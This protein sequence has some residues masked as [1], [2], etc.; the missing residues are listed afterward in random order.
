MGQGT[1]S[2]IP[3]AIDFGAT[4]GSL[5]GNGGAAAFAPTL[6]YNGTLVAESG[7]PV[8]TFFRVNAPMN[9]LATAF[10]DY[11]LAKWAATAGINV[12]SLPPGPRMALRWRKR[13]L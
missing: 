9:R 1:Y 2:Q 12:A 8:Q 10:L 5:G 6:Y 7:A 11:L 13:R 3:F 4:G